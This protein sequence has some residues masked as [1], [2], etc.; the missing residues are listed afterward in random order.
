M[1]MMKILTAMIMFTPSQTLMLIKSRVHQLT[2]ELRKV[3]WSQLSQWV[4]ILMVEVTTTKILMT[5]PLR[6]MMK[7]TWKEALPKEDSTM[8]MTKCMSTITRRIPIPSCSLV[9]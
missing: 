2:Q 5:N 4:K 8:R 7:K 9:P 3:R 1:L 6:K